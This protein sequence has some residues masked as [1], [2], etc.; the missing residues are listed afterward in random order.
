[1]EAVKMGAVVAVLYVLGV[2]LGMVSVLLFPAAVV[3]L[4]I[5]LLGGGVQ[6]KTVKYVFFIS[7]ATFLL[8][9]ICFA[10]PIFLEA[11]AALATGG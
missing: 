6:K 8:G 2:V 1:M 11:G 4:I 3:M 9:G 10:V 5:S 7:I